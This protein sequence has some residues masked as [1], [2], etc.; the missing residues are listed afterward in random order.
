[1]ELL[2]NGYYKVFKVA[3][4]VEEV[5]GNRFYWW[6]VICGFI[7]LFSFAGGVGVMLFKY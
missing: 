7:S 5:Q 4:N 2:S 6:A 1:M 3:T